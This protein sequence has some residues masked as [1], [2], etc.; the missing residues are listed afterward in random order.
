[1]A[2][3]SISIDQLVPGMYL[4]GVDISWID[5]PFLRNR[6]LVKNAAVIDKLKACGATRVEID[7]DKGM[8]VVGAPAPVDAPVEAPPPHQAP[9]QPQSAPPQPQPQPQP[10]PVAAQVAP[11]P[12]RPA[13]A[14]APSRPVVAA[15]PTA[16]AEYEE[17]IA[18]AKKIKSA[19]QQIMRKAFDTVRQGGKIEESMFGSLIE[20]TIGSSRRNSLAVLT[21]LHQQPTT[22]ELIHHAFNQMSM[23][24]LLGERMDLEPERLERLATA[25]LLMDIG[26]IRLPTTLLRQQYAYTDEEFRA[27]QEHVRHSVDILYEGGF[28]DEILQLVENHHERPDGSGYPEALVAS[29]IPLESQILSLVN[30]FES[31]VHGLYD[32]APQIPVKALRN[33]YTR[34]TEG[35]HDTALAKQLISIVGVYPMSSAV[36]LDSGERG[37]V[38]KVNWK[39][40]LKPIVR[41]IYGKDRQPLFEQVDVDLSKPVEAGGA[42]KIS[43]VLD[44]RNTAVDPRGLLIFS[45]L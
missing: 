27:I 9:P 18:R 37:V 2:K 36:E 33:I 45:E 23:A 3:K 19:G 28:D 13:A 22:K 17:E 35:G 29:E 42:K 20:H 41:L 24:V 32:S 43:N 40:P 7:T 4:V 34:G 31:N 30:H 1:M 14:K 10:A 38:V 39:Q 44:P 21:M 25:A 6:F 26:W 8:D 12:P 15:V 16:P 11:S 5:T